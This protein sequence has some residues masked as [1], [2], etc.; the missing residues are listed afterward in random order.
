M[1]INSKQNV[2]YLFNS[3]LNL[4]KLRAEADS[5][6]Q[7]NSF[8]CLYIEYLSR[9]FGDKNEFKD[10][11]T[12]LRH[13]CLSMNDEFFQVKLIKYFS[14]SLANQTQEFNFLI[15]F[16]RLLPE[17]MLLLTQTIELGLK[18]DERDKCYNLFKYFFINKRYKKFKATH[19][20]R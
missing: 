11:V 8:W 15:D 20:K 1:T 12:R 9:N 19:W 10:L 7:F 4:C 13:H 6:T 16:V 3:S 18:L 2:E 5:E 14:Q 17:N